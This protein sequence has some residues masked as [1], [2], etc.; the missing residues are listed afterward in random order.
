MK[1]ILSKIEKNALTSTSPNDFIFHSDYNSFKII[2][3]NTKTITISG[4]TY[5]QEYSD[6]H[7]LGFTPVISAFVKVQDENFFYLPN[8]PG[9]LYAG[10]KQ[11][12]SN[13]LWFQ[14]ISA[15]N[16]NV[17]FVFSNYSSSNKT[18]DIVYYLLE[19]IN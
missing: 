12:V 17:Y 8:S 14:Y 7:N 11:L 6:A 19:G 9:V 16:N 15:D 2:S 4:S 10:S 5:N 18:V 3:K 1:I 13:D